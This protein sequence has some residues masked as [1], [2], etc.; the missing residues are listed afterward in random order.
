MSIYDW[1]AE[2]I[3][4]YTAAVEALEDQSDPADDYGDHAWSFI[5]DNESERRWN[6]WQRE[7]AITKSPGGKHRADVK[8]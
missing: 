5:S 3:E 1:P 4:E 6:Y 2:A 7:I 8:R